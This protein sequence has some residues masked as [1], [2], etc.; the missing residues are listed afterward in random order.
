MTRYLP[1][2]V[3]LRAVGRQTKKTVKQVELE[4]LLAAPEGFGDDVP[5]DPNFHARR[6]P[7]RAWRQSRR[8]DGVEAV[9]Q[10]HRLR[11]VLALVGFTRFE[12]VTP[13]INGEYETDVERAQIAL[14]PSG[15]QQSRTA[16]RGCS[17]SLVLKQ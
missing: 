15:F 2:Y 4:A 3:T 13:D 1:R 17:S 9:I 16:V 11:E 5:I 8:S 14:E 10:V 7:A 6:L 12:A